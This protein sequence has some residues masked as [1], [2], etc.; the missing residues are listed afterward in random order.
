M[1][2]ISTLFPIHPAPPAPTGLYTSSPIKS[3]DFDQFTIRI[4]HRFN[5]NNTLFGRYSFSKENRFDTFDS[6]CAASNNVPGFGCNTLNGG[7]QAVID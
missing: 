7:Q 3:D 4:D 1:S 2:S 6:F 5:D